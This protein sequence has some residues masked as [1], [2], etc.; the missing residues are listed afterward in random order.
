MVASKGQ[1]AGVFHT[2]QCA[3]CALI[4]QHCSTMWGVLQVQVIAE[5]MTKR[6]YRITS[7][8]E[9]GSKNTFF[10]FNGD[11]T[12]IFDYYRKTYPNIK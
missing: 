7:L 6:E 3:A 8:T 9:R 4:Y 11:E 2:K 12:S 10:D 5:G 1:I